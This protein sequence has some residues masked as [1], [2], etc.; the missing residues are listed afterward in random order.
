MR[1]VLV[2][3]IALLS[4]LACNNPVAEKN[5]THSSALV[6]TNLEIQDPISIDSLLVISLSEALEQ[7]PDPVTDEE[8]QMNSGLGEFRVELYN[9][10]SREVYEKKEVMIREVTWKY[11][12]EKLVTL[13]YTGHA[14][15]WSYLHHSIWDQG[16]E[17]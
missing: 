1:M 5:S 2:F 14:D 8:F 16:S 17:F 4:L 10:I 7:Y 11:K 12:A 6:P 3:H 9:F 15:E 13:W